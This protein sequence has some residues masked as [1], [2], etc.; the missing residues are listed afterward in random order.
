M[1]LCYICYNFIT[2][3]KYFKMLM[4]FISCFQFCINFIRPPNRPPIFWT[5]SIYSIF[6]HSLFFLW[7]FF[8]RWCR[9]GVGGSASNMTKTM[10]MLFVFVIL[11]VERLVVWCV[12]WIPFCTGYCCFFPL[13]PF[14]VHF[15]SAWFNCFSWRVVH[16]SFV[17]HAP[18]FH[19]SNRV[20]WIISSNR[21]LLLLCFM[22]EGA[23]M[24][25]IVCFCFCPTKSKT[26][27]PPSQETWTNVFVFSLFQCILNRHFWYQN[28]SLKHR[29]WTWFD[30]NQY[31]KILLVFFSFHHTYPQHLQLIIDQMIVAV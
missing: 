12:C 20:V 15:H 17:L 4:I 2:K 27:K 25:H 6:H 19:S 18:K 16:F 1:N 13:F 3:W 26:Q 23:R 24:Y 9:S 29:V 28:L 8:G 30:T 31:R 10:R 21:S 5:Y 22:S 14:D 11:G 7:D